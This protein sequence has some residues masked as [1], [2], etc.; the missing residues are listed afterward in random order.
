MRRRRTGGGRESGGEHELNTRKAQSFSA[1]CPFPPLPFSPLP[2]LCLPP[3]SPMLYRLRRCG[4]L[5]S[6][7]TPPALTAPFSN[8]PPPYPLPL[9]SP[10]L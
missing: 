9:P 6:M 8:L 5:R 3:V 2:P 7:L 1:L 10:L 4:L